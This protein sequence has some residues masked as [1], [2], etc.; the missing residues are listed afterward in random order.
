MEQLRQ[1][2]RH[3]WRVVRRTPAF[4]VFVILLMALGIGATTAV[5]S[6]VHAVLLRPL[7]F[8]D[9]ERLMFVW[10]QRHAVRRN[11]VGG[12]EFPE[13]KARSRSFDVMAAIA[14]DRDYS[15]TG[16]GDPAALN[17][18][19]VTSD[20]F[21]VMGVLPVAGQVFGPDADQ[22][23]HGDVAV[24][25]HRL[26]TERFG[27]DPSL[28][29]RAIALNDRPHVVA[30][31][32]PADFQFPANGAGLGPD[33]WTP[34]A[35]PIQQY[36]GRHYLFVVGR[37]APGITKPQAQSEL[38]SIADGIAKEFPPNK[39]HGVNVQPRTVR[40]GGRC[41]Q[42]HPDPVCRR[43]CRAA[44]WMLQHRRTCCSR[45][46]LR[47]SRRSRSAPRSEPAGGESPVSCSRKGRCFRS[48]VLPRA[49]SSPGGSWRS[50]G[51]ACPETSQGSQ[52]W[53]SIR[54][55]SVSPWRSPSRQRWCSVS[56]PSGSCRAC[57][58]RTDSEPATREFH[59]RRA[60]RSAAP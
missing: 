48:A 25:S 18:V 43:R 58:W 3:A 56:F 55:P 53:R 50:R 42:R 33:L 29:G 20:F 24:I 47:G 12:H 15:L 35:E 17:G 28:V 7:P 10:E 6:V 41:A 31:V 9:P 5:F 14:F 60:I 27:A 39:A 4:S 40:A 26:W 22:P 2:V 21:K 38:T 23:G 52:P 45:V 34:I 32:M 44:G 30:A 8:K 49:W 51:P 37:L 54:R 13:W 19:R 36:R 57:R 11:A 16:A 59:H 46:R 1:D